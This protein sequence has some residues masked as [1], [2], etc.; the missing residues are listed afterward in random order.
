MFRASTA[1]G[2]ALDRLR[3]LTLHQGSGIVGAA[4]VSEAPVL[5]SD[6]RHD[7]RYIGDD[8]HTLSELAVETLLPADAAT[9]EILR[10]MLARVTAGAES[11]AVTATANP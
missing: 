1:Q 5:V 6:V 3:Q 9:G 11:P 2:D 7:A 8:W 4:A 10:Q